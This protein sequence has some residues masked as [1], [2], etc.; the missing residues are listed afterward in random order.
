MRMTTTQISRRA[1]LTLGFG[2]L[3]MGALAGCTAKSP[4]VKTAA[5]APAPPLKNW[6]SLDALAQKLITEK[7][8]PG[9]SLSVMLGGVLLY[10]K[11][12]GVADI[13]SGTPATPETGFRIA[14]ITKQFTAAATLKLV[15]LGKLSLDDSLA[16]F[17]PA[18]DGA[19]NV[20]IRHMLSHTSGMGD[21]INGQSK[22]ILVTAQ[23]TDYSADALLDIILARKPV[24]RIP[25]GV[26]WMYS[27]SAFAILGILIE[28]LSGMPFAEALDTW[29]FKPAGLEHTGIDR[30]CTVAS[31]CYGY[32]PDYRTD[33]GFDL[34]PPI[35]PSFGGGAGAL[36][37]SSDDLCRWHAALIG[38]RV[39]KLDTVRTMLTPVMLRNGQ[40]AFENRASEALEYGLGVAI[41]TAGALPLISHGGRINGFTGHLR[42]FPDARL[43]IAALYNSDGSGMGK[44]SAGQKAIRL[45]AARL[46]LAELGLA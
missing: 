25:P 18:I 19:E 22:D 29:L 11:G 7:L 40:P 24:F 44:F 31:A 8:T 36:R 6:P 9:L 35:S 10:S 28:R 42:S 1:G 39:L 14:S 37:S 20:T 3:A 13:G 38:G 32:S 30:S 15:E 23:H 33:T 34:N 21:Y 17:M 5:K 16:M 43:T 4:A 27:N 41:G 45:E 12:F 2:A 46:G 26:R